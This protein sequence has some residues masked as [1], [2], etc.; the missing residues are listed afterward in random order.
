LVT[1]FKN[2]Y[3]ERFP[4]FWDKF[5]DY[6]DGGYISS[7]REVRK[8]IAVQ[9]DRLNSWSKSNPHLFPIPSVDELRFITTIYSVDHFTFNL[10]KKKTI[11][12]WSIR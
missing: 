12:W 10:E 11:K 4:S 7:V 8:E 6:I 2:Y 9:D 1:I 3:P 5:Y